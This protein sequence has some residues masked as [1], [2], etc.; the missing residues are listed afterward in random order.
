MGGYYT[1]NIHISSGTIIDG[2]H[3]DRVGGEYDTGW[4]IVVAWLFSPLWFN[5]MAFEWEKTVDDA[6]QF[7]LWMAREEDDGNRSWKAWWKE[8]TDYLCKL[9]WSRKVTHILKVQYR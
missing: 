6:Q 7:A 5:P 2:E 4:L 8:E 3:T 9:E 1:Y